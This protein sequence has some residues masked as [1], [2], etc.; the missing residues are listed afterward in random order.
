MVEALG[1]MVARVFHEGVIGALHVAEAA[2][3]RRLH[4]ARL[5]FRDL[6]LGQAGVRPV[7]GHVSLLTKTDPP[8]SVV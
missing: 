5:G 4:A 8:A 7:L 2:D 6:R 1:R 3:T